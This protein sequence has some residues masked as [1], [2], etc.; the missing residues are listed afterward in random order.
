MANKE[1]KEIFVLKLSDSDEV[2]YY[3][4]TNNAYKCS[5]IAFRE[6]HIDRDIKENI[7]EFELECSRQGIELER[8]EE[9]GEYSI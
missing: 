7:L 4:I 5:L 2:I 9:W 6:N 3:Y 1:H 8:V